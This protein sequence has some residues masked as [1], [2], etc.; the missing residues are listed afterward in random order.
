MENK[1]YPDE[2]LRAGGIH[3]GASQGEQS[4]ICLPEFFG[5]GL[6]LGRTVFLITQGHIV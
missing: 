4:T 3:K 5:V 2:F 1:Q 6:N